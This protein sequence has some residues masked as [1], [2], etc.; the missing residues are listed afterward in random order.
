MA[1]N[2]RANTDEL[3]DPSTGGA[4]P[5][6]RP[7]Q[8]PP[9]QQPAPKV[10]T[11][12]GG[13]LDP[14]VNPVLGFIFGNDSKPGILGTGQYKPNEQAAQI[15]GMD[16][17]RAR[18]DYG[19]NQ[20][21]NANPGQ[22]FAN[23]QM[24]LAGDLYAAS[25]GQGPSVAQEQLRQ[26]TQANLA[27]NVAAAN[28]LRG[29]GGA[30]QAGQLAARQALAGQ[31]MA[32]DASL[33]RAQEVTQARGQLAGVL[34]QGREQDMAAEAQRQQI[35]QQYLQLGLT[36]EQAAQQA[37]MDLERL[38]QGSYYQTADNQYRVVKDVASGIG[39]LAGGM[40]GG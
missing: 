8:T 17:L 12:G 23:G 6:Q 11:Q 5:P 40:A 25:Q 7:T 30:A 36:A 33:L 13:I 10:A 19:Y 22:Q 4:P 14:N 39:N 18:T 34:G 29:P 16:T 21:L 28:S 15:G 35:A 9:P 31:Q 27:A 2:W 20:A 1:W 3:A 32:G 37:A 24:A 38:K 26:G